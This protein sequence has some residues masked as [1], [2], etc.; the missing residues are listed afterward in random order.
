M[1]GVAGEAKGLRILVADDDE[2]ILNILV[3][4]LRSAGHEP[5]PVARGD[6]ALTELLAGAFDL[7]ILDVQMP[8][9]G[10][11][12]IV[13]RY[14][15]ETGG[16]TP[17]IVLTADASL[18]TGDQCRTLGIRKVLTKPITQQPLLDAISEVTQNTAIDSTNPIEP[19]MGNV[20]HR[21]QVLNLKRVYG[22]HQSV[23]RAIQ[24]LTAHMSELAGQLQYAIGAQDEAAIHRIAHQLEGCASTFGAKSVADFCIGI[25]KKPIST[26]SVAECDA[27][28]DTLRTVVAVIESELEKQWDTD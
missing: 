27:L 13:H 12:E 19:E 16:H 1:T 24:R 15:S 11:L 7:A 3:R 4:M 17:F 9:I 26:I 5:R 25:R 8:G 14:R 22:D 2:W 23:Q 18:K 21:K 6:D 20:I 28:S 10:A